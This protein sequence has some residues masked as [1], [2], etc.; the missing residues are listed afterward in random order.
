VIG[1]LVAHDARMQ[2]RNGFHA[3]YLFVVVSYIVLL[4][5]LPPGLRAAVV[6]PVLLSEAA[7]VGFFFAGA[8]LHFERGDGTLH[9]IAVTPVRTRDYLAARCVSLCALNTLVALGVAA[10]ADLP[11]LDLP[12]LALAAVLTALF[13][14]LLGTAVASRF[15]GIDRFVV[16]GGL[17]SALLGLAVFPYFGVGQTPLWRILPTDAAL[18][19]LGGATTTP[20]VVAG[21]PGGLVPDVAL[22]FHAAAAAAAVLLAWSAGAGLLARRW[23]DVHAL[24]RGGAPAA[25]VP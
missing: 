25:R 9:A 1:T 14:T 23:V 18:R 21:G 5:L 4:R 13:F 2:F 6:A 19:L 8:L 10:G 3:A 11:R 24:G 20:D 22:T 15:G 16:L 7:V 12:L 17:V